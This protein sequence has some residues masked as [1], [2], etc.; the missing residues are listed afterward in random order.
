MQVFTSKFLTILL[1]TLHA[2]HLGAVCFLFAVFALSNV[3]QCFRFL[4]ISL[5]GAVLLP[6]I[7]KSRLTPDYLLS[8]TLDLSSPET[9]KIQAL[10]M[11]LTKF[12]T[13]NTL[14]ITWALISSWCCSVF[15]YCFYIEWRGHP[16]RLGL[17]SLLTQG[18]TLA[19]ALVPLWF[20]ARDELHGHNG[21]FLSTALYTEAACVIS[22]AS[23][24][25]FH[26]FILIPVIFAGVGVMYVRSLHSFAEM[27]AMRDFEATQYKHEFLKKIAPREGD[28]TYASSIRF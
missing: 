26:S 6:A 27:D 21:Y 5:C 22:A 23:L 14:W 11:P 13:K 25:I 28:Q 8:Q 4:I 19:I 7:L 16:F 15:L 12:F 9:L 17:F 20:M 3:L 2:A 18:A 10:E 24:L 1:F